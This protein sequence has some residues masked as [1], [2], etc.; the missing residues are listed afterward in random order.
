MANDRGSGANS[1]V[2]HGASF[3]L[4]SPDGA[5]RFMIRIVDADLDNT[6]ASGPDQ[7]SS[8][9]SGNSSSIRRRNRKPKVDDASLSYTDTSAD[10]SF[11]TQTGTIGAQDR[12]T[13]RT[14]LRFSLVDGLDQS[15]NPLVLDGI[16]YDQALESTYTPITPATA[17]AS[18]P[19]QHHRPIRL[20]SQRCRH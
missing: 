2:V 14:D 13:N 3:E 8:N 19:Q 17:T 7:L 18:S 11:D 9:R 15:G 16:S 1:G 20:C 10:D 12:E 6:S 4:D 5:K